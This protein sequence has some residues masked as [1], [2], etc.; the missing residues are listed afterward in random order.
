MADKEV[1]DDVTYKGEQG[2]LVI[3]DKVFH[4]KAAHSNTSVKCSWARVEK[5]QLSPENSSTHMI[6]LVLVSGKTAIF[7]V[8]DRRTL[9][10]IRKDAQARMDAAKKGGKGDMSK[11]QRDVED[12]MDSNRQSDRKWADEP[13]SRRNSNNNNNNNDRSDPCGWC[14]VGTLVCWLCTCLCC[15]AILA[16][17]FC[18]YWFVYRDN[19]DEIL[20]Q[21]GINDGP[22]D[23]TVP[24]DH[25]QESRYGIR[26]V[27]HDWN[28]EEVTLTYQVSDY[29]LDNSLRYVL[30]DGL[31][32]R[33]NNNDITRG[34]TYL[35]MEM[36]LPKDGG[37]D[38]SNEGRG[39][40]QVEIHFTINKGEITSAPFYYPNGLEK[41]RLNF[42]IGLLVNYNRVD[43]WTQEK[44]VCIFLFFLFQA[45]FCILSV[46]QLNGT[47]FFFQG[48]RCGNS[49][50]S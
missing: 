35:F 28:S 11:S 24:P 13:V 39:S 45:V 1:Y 4:Y 40:R 47:G 38:L 2:T 31:E 8:K 50:S 22:V 20:K 41:A 48:Q 46:T 37:A 19:E 29:I 49:R 26:S 9:D 7:Q 30:Y 17:A 44:E 23:T 25:G 43:Y 34:N 42:C 16:A 12:R 14:C 5:R 21:I 3:N 36:I 33:R 18:V 32:C 10:E 15:L 27:N 6:K